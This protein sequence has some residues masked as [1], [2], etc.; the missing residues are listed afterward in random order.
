MATTKERLDA[1]GAGIDE[2]SAQ[3]TKAQ[4]EIEK[5]VADLKALIEAGGNT[6]PDIE[7]SLSAIETKVAALKPVSQALDDLNVDTP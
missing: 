3:L 4:G 1:I 5:E 6:S 2:V 7:A